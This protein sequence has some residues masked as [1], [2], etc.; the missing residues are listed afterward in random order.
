MAKQLECAVCGH[1][2]F[3]YLFTPA[4]APGPVSKCR[5]CGFIF[6]SYLLNDAA[7]I[8]DGP[9]IGD[10]DP[11]LLTSNDLNDLSQ[12]WEAGLLPSKEREWPAIQKDGGTA[13]TKVED[14]VSPPGRLLD[15]GCG[16]G[17][18]LQVARSRGWKPYGIEPLPGTALHARARFGMDVVADVLR[19]DTYADDYFDVVTAF[20]VFEHLPDPN[21]VLSILRRCIRPGGVIL[22]EV[23]NIDTWSFRLLGKRHRHFVE[24][25]LQFFSAATLGRLL[26]NHE[27][28][29]METSYPT[30]HMTVTHLTSRWLTHYLPG[31]A[32]ETLKRMTSSQQ[33][34]VIG[35][36]S[37]DIVTVVGR[38]PGDLRT[39]VLS[40]LRNTTAARCRTNSI[41][42]CT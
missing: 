31:R 23:P 4:R 6:V 9:A 7:V 15:F 32:A 41:E 11:A 1:H 33:H 39:S 24:D 18:F 29:V 5:N 19:D 20:Q 10:R 21:E 37:R 42:V 35:L 13:L 40:K 3:K 22:I 8:D 27:I 36:N 26:E 30:R 28:E 2:D 34:R 25:H 12:C 14:Y 17:F 38:I 16:W